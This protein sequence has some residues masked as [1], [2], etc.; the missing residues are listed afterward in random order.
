VRLG[1]EIVVGEDEVRLLVG[2]DLIDDL[3]R[4]EHLV[5]HAQPV[6]REITEAAA[7]VTAAR[8]DQARRREER[9]AIENV[10]P[11]GGVVAIRLQVTAAIDLL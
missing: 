7:V 6:G 8:G 11:R 3:L 1:A 10:A 2:A 5:G 4:V 9:R